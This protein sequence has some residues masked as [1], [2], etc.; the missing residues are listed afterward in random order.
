ME[1]AYRVEVGNN[2]IFK[3]SSKNWKRENKKANFL[4]SDV[5][6]E[7]CVEKL[8]DSRR[9]PLLPLPLLLLRPSVQRVYQLG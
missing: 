2:K 3:D 9:S 5:T 8:V 6:A 1:K 4:N 7:K